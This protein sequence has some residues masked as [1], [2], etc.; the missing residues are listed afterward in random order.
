MAD[1]V[2][3]IL[4]IEDDPHHV[5]LIEALIRENHHSGVSTEQVS[6]RDEAMSHLTSE[7]HDVCLLDYKLD[8]ADGLTL[9]RSVRAEGVTMPVIFLTSSGSEDIAVEA[10]KA[11]ASD[12]IRKDN[13]SG[14]LLWASMRHAIELQ[15]EEERRK[16]AEAALRAARDELEI[17]VQERTAELLAAYEAL[18]QADQTKT[19]MIQNVAHEFRTPLSYLVGY[20]GLMLEDVANVDSLSGEGL[21]Q[22]RNFLDKVARA[23]Q[24]LTRLVENFTAIQ[25]LHQR[26]LHCKPAHLAPLIVEAVESAGLT[27]RD[28]QIFLSTNVEPDLPMVLVDLMALGQVLDNLITNAFKFTEAGGEVTVRAWANPSDQM[29][30]VA[31]ADTGIGILPELHERVFERFYQVDGSPTR[32]YGGIGLGLAVCREIVDAMGGSIWVESEPGSGTTFTFTLP[33]APQAITD[34]DEEEALASP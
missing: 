11:G 29:V 22:L 25:S 18:Q 8:D 32:G 23:T 26:K 34:P 19:E 28:Q 17:R 7:Q 20:T 16:K 10:M 12:Y 27:A 24:R 2:N 21:E 3:S 9:L 31:V 15:H 33:V 13:L 30:Y 4:I 1:R 6:C 14:E 5:A